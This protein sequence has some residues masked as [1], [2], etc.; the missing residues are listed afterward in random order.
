MTDKE[1]NEYIDKLLD[2]PVED[3]VESNGEWGSNFD[4]A[5]A[6]WTNRYPGTR[7]PA[8]MK[9]GKPPAC[10]AGHVPPIYDKEL[11]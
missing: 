9:V 8:F 3:R 2:V 10:F 1:L 4:W 5:M 7:P 6:T 11:K